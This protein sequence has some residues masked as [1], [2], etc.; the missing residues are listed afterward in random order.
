MI[1]ILAQWVLTITPRPMETSHTTQLRE[2]ST[3]VCPKLVH[4][5]LLLGCLLLLRHHHPWMMLVQMVRVWGARLH[6]WR[7]VM[8]GGLGLQ[9]GGWAGVWW[10]GLR[11]RRRLWGSHLVSQ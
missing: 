5:V 6:L 11:T 4:R 1:H 10:L 3:L 9:A 8:W 2:H 7:D